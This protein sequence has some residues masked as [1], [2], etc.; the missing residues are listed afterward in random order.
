VRVDL[1]HQ[2][3]GPACV[4]PLGDHRL[5]PDGEPDEHV[6]VLGALSSRGGGQQPAVGDG[7]EP[8]LGECLVR[9]GRG[10]GVAERL[11]GDQQMPRDRLQVGRVTVEQTV[12]GEHD[13]GAVAEFA[14]EAPD[15]PGDLPLVGQHE[16]LDVG[17]ERWQSAPWS[18]SSELLAPLS[19]QP[20]LSDDEPAE[21]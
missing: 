3:A 20:T 15:L 2:V 8:E 4:E 18:A 9:P 17:R 6:E 21:A 14:V 19:E 1:V 5:I 16:Q 10:V 11:V 7:S 13:T 12:R